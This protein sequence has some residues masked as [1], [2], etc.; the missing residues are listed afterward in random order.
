MCVKFVELY[1]NYYEVNTDQKQ[2]KLKPKILAHIEVINHKYYYFAS[3]IDIYFFMTIKTTR[4][5]PIKSKG[6]IKLEPKL[7]KVEPVVF[8]RL[9]ARPLCLSITLFRS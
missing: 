4:P 1:T 5:P 2:R 9:L 3:E 7:S 6:N 8:I